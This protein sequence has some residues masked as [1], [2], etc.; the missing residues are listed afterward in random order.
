MDSISC[1]YDELKEDFPS[2]EEF[3]RERIPRRAL[4]KTIELIAD[5]VVDVAMIVISAKGLEKP[6][7]SC[8][9]I[10]VLAKSGILS[11]ALADKM[12]DFIR[13]RNLL[14]HQYAKVDEHRE[15]ETIRDNHEDIIKF[16][17]EI[18]LF[19]RTEEKKLKV[20]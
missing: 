15:F 5:A 10:A 6:K 8:D 4:E 19:V 11:S 7:E 9:S 3:S 14:V 13:F 2:E 16:L 17:K 12:K 18:E 1:Y 20:R